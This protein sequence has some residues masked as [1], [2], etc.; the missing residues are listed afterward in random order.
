MTDNTD[1]TT[2]AVSPVAAMPSKVKAAPVQ[3]MMTRN[4]KAGGKGVVK[5]L[6]P[7]DQ[8]A[9]FEAAGWTAEA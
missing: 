9:D 2:A 6:V 3:I 8:I 5:M 1:N 4:P 7:A